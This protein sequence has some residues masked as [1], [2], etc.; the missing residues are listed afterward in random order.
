MA[1]NTAGPVAHRDESARHVVAS[2]E[3]YAEAERAVDHLADARFD[4]SPVAIIGRELQYVEQVVG[5]LDCA[6]AA[7]RGAAAG[8][9][10]GAVIGWIFGL[11][12]WIQ[13]LIAGL[14]L[15]SYGL[16]LGAVLGAVIG[17]ALHAMQRGRRD[18]PAVARSTATSSPTS[19]WPSARE[20][21]TGRNEKE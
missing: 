20:I 10:P 7:W 5:P 1:E 12:N 8:A 17:L 2:F 9:V 15:A 11:F 13:P 4:V 6:G 21:L 3:D 19:T 18:V 14:V 16:I